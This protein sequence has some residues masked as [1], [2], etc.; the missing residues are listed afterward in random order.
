[1]SES[2]PFRISKAEIQAIRQ[3]GEFAL[4]D[5]PFYPSTPREL[6]QELELLDSF[7]V[8]AIEGLGRLLPQHTWFE[9]QNKPGDPLLRYMTTGE[10]GYRAWKRLD[11]NPYVDREKASIK[12]E[13]TYDNPP[14]DHLQARADLTTAAPGRRAFGL[15]R[16]GRTSEGREPLRHVRVDVADQYAVAHITSINAMVELY[17]DDCQLRSTDEK[18]RFVPAYNLT[19]DEQHVFQ[20]YKAPG[21]LYHEIWI[22]ARSLA[23]CTATALG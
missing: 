20:T 3:L 9:S 15:L 4:E 6:L 18:E 14:D 16:R 13:V 19:E 12:L 8:T 5:I 1:M 2:G 22:C 10:Q 23:V 21:L 17:G 7:C 11:T